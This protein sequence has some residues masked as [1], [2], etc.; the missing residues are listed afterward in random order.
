MAKRFQLPVFV[1]VSLGLMFLFMACGGSSGGGGDVVYEGSTDPAVADST[2]ATVLAEYGIGSLE[3]GFPLAGPFVTPPPEKVRVLS[4]EPL[5]PYW[6]TTVTVDVPSEAVYYGND[7]DSKYGSG[8]A[9]IDGSMTMVLGNNTA[10]DANTWYIVEVELD[11]SIYFDDFC[12]GDQP[13]I[14]GRVTIPYGLFT[15]SGNAAFLLSTMEIPDDP[16]FPIWEE[17]LMTFTKISVTD[18]EESWSL[19]EGEWEMTLFAGSWVDLDIISMTVGYQGDTFKLEDTNLYVEMNDDPPQPAALRVRA[20]PAFMGTEYTIINISGIDYKAGTFYHPDLGVIEFAGNLLESDPPGDLVEGNLTFYS[21]M[22][23]TLYNI[24][25]DY[26]DDDDN[27]YDPATYYRLDIDEYTERGY[28]IDGSFIPT[29]LAP[30][31][32]IIL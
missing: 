18:G 12:T 25:F 32:P 16:G 19:G 6:E 17:V 28:F 1:T 26:D 2:N 14:T 22:G 8:T 20:V 21:T 15:F 5:I 24:W 23:A 31:I 7:Y 29:D 27:I 30:L 10:A 13:A 9:D 11:G 4:A 3:A